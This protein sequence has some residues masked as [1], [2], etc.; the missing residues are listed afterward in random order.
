MMNSSFDFKP[1]VHSNYNRN[2]T[3][4]FTPSHPQEFSPFNSPVVPLNS[5]KYPGS[6]QPAFVGGV[7]LSNVHSP[8]YSPYVNPTARLSETPVY[9]PAGLTPFDSRLGPSTPVTSY[10]NKIK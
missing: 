8:L 7:K 6:L 1:S 4:M 3:P 2:N 9:V 5:P 10:A